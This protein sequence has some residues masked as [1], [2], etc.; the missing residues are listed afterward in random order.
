LW[1]SYE[2]QHLTREESVNAKVCVNTTDTYNINKFITNSIAAIGATGS[3]QNLNIKNIRIYRFPS[4]NTAGTDS[5]M[6]NDWNYGGSTYSQTPNSLSSGWVKV[7]YN[8][9]DQ[10]NLESSLSSETSGNWQVPNPPVLANP[11][12]CPGSEFAYTVSSTILDQDIISCYVSDDR[13]FINFSITT[14]IFEIDNTL[15]YKPL[16]FEASISTLSSYSFV[17]N[18]SGEFFGK[19][20][21][22]YKYNRVTHNLDLVNTIG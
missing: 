3:T 9:S 20:N 10:S 6:Y 12:N 4:T 1:D 19:Q 7:M 5:Y 11:T 13:L 15:T 8:S 16:L 21:N 22:M 2:R 17:Y 14:M 18:N